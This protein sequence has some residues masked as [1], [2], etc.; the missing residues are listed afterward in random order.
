MDIE[1]RCFN[2]SQT[3]TEQLVKLLHPRRFL[4]KRRGLTWGLSG[5]IVIAPKVAQ[6]KPV[7]VFLCGYPDPDPYG[8]IFKQQQ[9]KI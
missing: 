4:I 7:G 1:Q 5:S 8:D 6:G 3:V 2:I 9:L